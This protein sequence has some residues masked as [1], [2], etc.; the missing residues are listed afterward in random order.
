M[1]RQQQ[2]KTAVPWAQKSFL[3][4]TEKTEN[5]DEVSVIGWLSVTEY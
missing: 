5:N 3:T 2:L 4:T 1:T